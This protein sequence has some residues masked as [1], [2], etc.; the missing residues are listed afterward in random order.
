[1]RT[2]RAREVLT[3][4]VPD[5]LQAFSGSGDPDTA[6]AGFDAALARMPAA[7]ELFSKLKANP[8]IRE[9]FSDIL[10]GPPGSPGW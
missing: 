9:L 7:V 10:G 4:L 1:M 2:P 6:L 5:L 3:D 8:G